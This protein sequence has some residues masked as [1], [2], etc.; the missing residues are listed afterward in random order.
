MTGWAARDYEPGDEERI[1]DLFELTYGKR[2][3]IEHWRWMFSECPFGRGIMKLLFDGNVLVGHYAVVPMAVEIDGVQ[4]NAA[5]SVDT[6]THVKHRGRGIFAFLAS[7]TYKECQKRG[8]ALVYGFP[9]E[10]SHKG[11]VNRLRWHSFGH[12][13]NMRKKLPIDAKS[14]PNSPHDVHEVSFFGKNIDELWRSISGHFPVIVPRNANYLNWRFCQK[15]SVDY[16]K[17]VMNDETGVTI[18]YAVLKS[19]EGKEHVVGHIVDLMCVDARVLPDI[20]VSCIRCFITQG[21]N[22][23]SLWVPMISP[24]RKILER[25]GFVEEAM[26]TYFGVKLLSDDMSLSEKVVSFENWYL[27]MGDSDVF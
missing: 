13:K 9:N 3:S 26:Q 4:S 17:L 24:A 11:F 7:E 19:Y 21:I 22:E 14:I 5:L 12:M 18:G 8:L 10:N 23:V 25:W 15:P 27:S 6:M 20:L 1:L 2:R 16:R